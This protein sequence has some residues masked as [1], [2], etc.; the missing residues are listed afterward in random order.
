MPQEEIIEIK[1]HF[2]EEKLSNYRLAKMY[3][4]SCVTIGMIKKGITHRY[5]GEDIWP[6][7][8]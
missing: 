4:V 5:I 3:N 2:V 1:K 8:K 6:C 7:C